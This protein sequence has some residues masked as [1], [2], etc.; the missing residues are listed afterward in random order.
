MVFRKFISGRNGK[1]KLKM[2]EPVYLGLSIPE[3]SKTLMYELLYDHIK[4]KYQN[5]AKL[6]YMD[7]VL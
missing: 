3:I 6:C 4:A 7:T 5:N 2:N 1:K